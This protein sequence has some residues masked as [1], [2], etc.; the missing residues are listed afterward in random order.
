ML[1]P[2]VVTAT[3]D[4]RRRPRLKLEYPVCLYRSGEA[5]PVET[6]TEDM[7]CEGFFCIT[8]QAFHPRETLECALVIPS[9]ELGL[10]AEHDFVLRCRAEVVRV[11][12]RDDSTA[13]GVA[14]RLADYTLGRHNV[15]RGVAIP[16]PTEPESRAYLIAAP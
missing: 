5:S 7:S 4:R 8:E 9:E 1:L 2:I 11:V 15:E 10:P 16:C 14:C 6:K 12:P 13:F 3:A